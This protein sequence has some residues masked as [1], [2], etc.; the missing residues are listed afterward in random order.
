MPAP[1]KMAPSAPI[2]IAKPV[3]MVAAFGWLRS[4]VAAPAIRASGP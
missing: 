4:T 3:A 2:H 1:E